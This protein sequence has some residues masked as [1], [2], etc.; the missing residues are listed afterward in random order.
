MTIN[1][2]TVRAVLRTDKI[3]KNGTCPIYV[4]LQYNNVTQKFSTSEFIE[5]KYWDKDKEQGI[6]KGFGNLNAVIKKKKQNLEDFIRESKS[7]GRPLSKTDISNFWNGKTE[8]DNEILFSTFYE[9]YCKRHFQTIRKSTQIH[10]TTLGK[11]IDDFKPNLMVSEIDYSF[12]VEFDNYL[13]E[14]KSGRYNMIK[15]LKTVLKEAVKL[16]VLKNESWKGLKNVSPNAREVYL[17]PAEINKIEICDLSTKK[18]L[19]LTRCMF[20]F[21]CYTGMRYSDVVALKKENYKN[22]VITLKQVK[23]GVDLKVPVNLEAKKIICKYWSKRKENENIFP[24]IENQTV[25]R[26]LKKIGEIAELKKTLHFHVA[27]HTFGTTLLNN[28]VN[29]FYIS[30]MMGH[31]KLSQT[32]AYTGINVNKM[33]DIMGTVNFQPKNENNNLNRL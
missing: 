21:S 6:G 1:Y 2:Y 16:G 22:G 26:Y 5:E 29:V 23:T 13:V 4:V 28:N 14:T 30:K 7:I 11:K 18:H 17:T 3:R 27:R 19:E 25:N 31:K 9:S 15:F 8:T 24:R 33:K 12:M 20:L 10:Y 32:Y